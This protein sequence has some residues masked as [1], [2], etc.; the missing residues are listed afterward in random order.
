MKY[1]IRKATEEDFPAVL[2]LIKEL[3]EFEKAPEQVTN[4]VEQMKREKDYFLC[5]VAETDE[6]EIIGMAL[7]YFV[8]YTWVGKSLYLD[9]IYIRKDFRKNR[10]GSALLRKVFE[11]AKAEDCRR[12]RWQVLNWNEPAIEMY[13]SIGALI[14]DEWLNCT[15]D[16]EGISNFLKTRSP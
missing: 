1:R 8:Y 15:F 7:F 11:V 6:K 4:S 14:E 10:V 12:I 3:A 9:D 16:A 13:R 5:Y 2:S